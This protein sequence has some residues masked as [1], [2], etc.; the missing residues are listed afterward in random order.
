MWRYA[1]FVSCRCALSLGSLKGRY[2]TVGGDDG[3]GFSLGWLEV[4]EFWDEVPAGRQQG[5]RWPHRTHPLWVIDCSQD[6]L[7]KNVKS[8]MILILKSALLKSQTTSPTMHGDVRTL[9]HHHHWRSIVSDCPPSR[10]PLCVV[11]WWWCSVDRAM[12]WQISSM[13]ALKWAMKHACRAL[14]KETLINNLQRQKKKR[15]QI[16]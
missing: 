8:P 16:M 6:A 3:L 1:R 2:K 10:W 14:Q 4:F 9:H 11:R 12:Q 15:Q 13:A 7:S 5:H